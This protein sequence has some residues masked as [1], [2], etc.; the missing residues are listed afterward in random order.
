[1]T[2]REAIYKARSVELNEAL[3]YAQWEM[4]RNKNVIMDAGERLLNVKEENKKLKRLLER[5]LREAD[6]NA[7]LTYQIERVLE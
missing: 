6:L 4:T 2:E 3:G 5:V 7:S 1:M